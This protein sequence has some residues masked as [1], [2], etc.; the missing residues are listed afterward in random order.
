[1]KTYLVVVPLLP[2]IVVQAVP[3]LVEAVAA[4]SLELDYLPAGAVV[5]EVVA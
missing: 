5:R 4:V 3:S 1:M 2:A